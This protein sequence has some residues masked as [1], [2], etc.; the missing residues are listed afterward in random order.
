MVRSAP[1]GQGWTRGVYG[2]GHWGRPSCMPPRPCAR[3][4]RGQAIAPSL[5]FSLCWALFSSPSTCRSFLATP[6]QGKSVRMPRWQATPKPTGAEGEAGLEGQRAYQ[7][8]D[9]G[10]GGQIRTR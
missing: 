2:A 9:C 6:M 5:T 1:A 8:R 4:P 10:D 7:A 3:P